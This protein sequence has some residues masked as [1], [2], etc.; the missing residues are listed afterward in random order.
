MYR[1]IENIGDFFTP[2]YYTED[3]ISKV[4]SLSGYDGDAI[5]EFNKRF[6]GLKTQYFET[7]GHIKS[8]K[9]HKKYI[10][11]ETHDFNT[12]IMAA[13]GYDT[14]PAYANW[15]YVD[16]SSVIPARSVLYNGAQARLVV[17]E[18]QAMIKSNEDDVPAGLFEQQYDDTTE[19][20]VKE[21]KY[22]YSQWATVINKDLPEG[23]KI[24]PSKINDCVTAIFRLPKEQKPQYIVIFAG[25]VIF[26]MEQDKWDHGAY[27]KFDLEELFSEAA[28]T[29][30]KNYYS[31]FYLLASKEVLASDAQI[32]L[33]DKIAEESFKNAYEVTK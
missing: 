28:I 12:K 3:F 33:M 24:S 26:L 11:Q 4:I 23:C 22:I 1:F 15:I 29:A 9:L 17:L 14:T 8:Q 7:K 21:Q 20:T 30:N 2:G 27:V 25:N 18:M 5:K 6:S 16:E 13:L 32:V 31:L 19:K 10:I